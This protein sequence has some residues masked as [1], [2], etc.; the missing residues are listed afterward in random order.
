ML[1]GKYNPDT[2]I[3]CG[4]LDLIFRLV[5]WVYSSGNVAGKC[6]P[7]VYSGTNSR[8]TSLSGME[9]ILTGCSCWYLHGVMHSWEGSS[10]HSFPLVCWWVSS[11]FPV[12]C[13]WRETVSS[14]STGPSSCSHYPVNTM[15]GLCIR[16]LLRLRSP[17]WYSLTWSLSY[18]VR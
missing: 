10:C 2:L 8:R 14:Y 17:L 15:Q 9:C 1:L 11:S 18:K 6:R 3:S 16:I 12:P 13:W 7:W 4:S 5:S